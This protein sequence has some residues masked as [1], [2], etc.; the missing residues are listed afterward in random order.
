MFKPVIASTVALSMMLAGCQTVSPSVNTL[1]S[2]A[3]AWA[4]PVLGGIQVSTIT[5]NP[6]EQAILNDA[7]A[8]C[9]AY[10]ANPTIAPATV[11]TVLV[12]AMT[13]IAD[14]LSSKA[15]KAK[16]ALVHIHRAA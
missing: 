12:Q 1:V 2:E 15:P 3:L 14:S 10:Q 16:R 9:N 7:V 4:C 8:D 13:I 6:T 5:L 11:A